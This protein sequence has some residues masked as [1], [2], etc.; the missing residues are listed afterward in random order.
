MS[1]IIDLGRSL[2]Q[3]TDPRFRHV[4]WKSLAI[5]VAGLAALFVLVMLLLGIFL[6]DTMTLPWIGTVGF[7]D[8]LVDWTAVL[9]MLVLSVVLMVPVTAAVVGFFLEDVAEAVEVRHYPHLGPPHRLRVRQQITDALRFFGLVV[10]VN[11]GALVVYLFSAPLA[12]FVFWAVNG[13][14][15]G[16]EYFLLVAIRRVTR[17]AAEAMWRRYFWRIWIAGTAIAVPLSV[18]ILNLVVPMIGVAVFTHQ[19]HR[20]KTNT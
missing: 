2:A 13:F 18:P 8:T 19:F 15:L 12:P 6:P 3:L 11:I 10:L 9:L 20:L 7:V 17:P 4:L 5:S 14:L 16:R 1:L